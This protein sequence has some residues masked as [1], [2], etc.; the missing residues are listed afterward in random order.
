MTGFS[1]TEPPRDLGHGVIFPLSQLAQEH[2]G[3]AAVFAV[4]IPILPQMGV[5][6]QGSPGRLVKD[7]EPL[8]RQIGGDPPLR[9]S[10]AA[11]ERRVSGCI[12]ADIRS[13]FLSFRASGRCH[14]RGNP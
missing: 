5:L 3:D 12:P 8:P 9:G 10:G 11:K 2:E 1:T 6:L 14:W 4:Q 7:G 13:P